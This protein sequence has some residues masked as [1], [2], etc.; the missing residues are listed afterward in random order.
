MSILDMALLSTILTVAHRAV[1]INWGSLSVGVLIMKALLL[2]VYTRALDFG[3]TMFTAG[4]M[5][6]VANILVPYS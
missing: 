3:T 4:A 5:S 2:G 1:S 6:I